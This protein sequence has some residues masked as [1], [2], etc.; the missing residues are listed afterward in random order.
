MKHYRIILVSQQVEKQKFHKM[1]NVKFLIFILT[2]F[3]FAGGLL[4]CSNIKITETPLEEEL[5]DTNELKISKSFKASPKHEI[6]IESSIADVIMQ[7]HDANEIEVNFYVKGL[8]Q[9]LKEFDVSFHEEENRLTIKVKRKKK[10][11]ILN[12]YD[13][14]DLFQ[15]EGI[16]TPQLVV[17]APDSLSNVVIKSS[18]G[19]IKIQNF[20]SNFEL[21]SAGGDIQIEELN[22]EIYASSSGG[23]TRIRNCR[24]D[25]KIKTA[26]GDIIVSQYQGKIEIESSGGDI[27][28]NK[29]NGSIFA[30]SAGGDVKVEFALPLGTTK[31]S[32]AGGDITIYAPSNLNAYVDLE[33]SG[34]NIKVD[35]PTRIEK[36]SSFELKGW[37]GKQN[38]ETTIK[39]S[40]SGGDIELISKDMN[41]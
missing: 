22:G 5:S 35:F 24:G 2:G 16:E 10:V 30:F 3:I 33:S 11:R 36:K 18:G 21:S 23:D 41:I 38:S 29:L 27:T 17:K 19:D 4:L 28:V 31:L 12:F 6:I 7:S 15:V 26:G 37:I 20:T 40:S 1:M 34:G 14:F 9:K 39:A 8:S 32:T 25:S 13:L